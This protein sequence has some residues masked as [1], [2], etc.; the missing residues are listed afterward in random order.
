MAIAGGVRVPLATLAVA[1]R[2]TKGAS[3]SHYPVQVRSIAANKEDYE[4]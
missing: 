3:C 2:W 4:I 1:R